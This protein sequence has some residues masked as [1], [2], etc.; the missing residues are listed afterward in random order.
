MTTNI[1][2]TDRTMSRD[3]GATSPSI[4]RTRRAS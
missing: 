4:R 1:S 3:S 2:P